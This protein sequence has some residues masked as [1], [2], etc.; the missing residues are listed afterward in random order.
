MK[1]VNWPTKDETIKYA[2]IIDWCFSGYFSGNIG[3]YLYSNTQS[4][5]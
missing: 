2:L 1:K 3:F 4:I 5:Y